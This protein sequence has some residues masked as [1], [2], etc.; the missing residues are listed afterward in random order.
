[1]SLLMTIGVGLL[2]GVDW[3]VS[4]GLVAG[5]AAVVMMSVAS[6]LYCRDR[7]RE[8]RDSASDDHDIVSDPVPAAP[9]VAPRRR[10]RKCD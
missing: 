1:M 8:A 2:Q 10:T 3:R 4:A 5:A 6:V 7:R 9:I